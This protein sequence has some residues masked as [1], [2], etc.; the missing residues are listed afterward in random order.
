[1]KTNVSGLSAILERKRT[2]KRAAR[3]KKNREIEKTIVLK[4]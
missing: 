4:G 3:M 2:I 1:L